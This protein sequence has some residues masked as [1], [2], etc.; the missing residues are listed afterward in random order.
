[1]NYNLNK[2]AELGQKKSTYTA[3][4]SL[5][6]LIAHERKNLLLALFA[7]LLNATLNLLGPYL[8]GHTLIP[9]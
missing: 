8:I 4:K 3:L 1:M 6:Q 9:M 7:I 2:L 5:L